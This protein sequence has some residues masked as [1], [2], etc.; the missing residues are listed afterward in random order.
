M[1]PYS[2]GRN[3]G[4]HIA[5]RPNAVKHH[6]GIMKETDINKL[7]EVY[8]S[9]CQFT[10]NLRPATLRGYRAA[11][12]VFVMVVE[13]VTLEGLNEDTMNYFFKG[14]R[15]RKRIVG[16]NKVKTD[17]RD[18]T[19]KTYWSKLNSFFEWLRIRGHINSNPLSNVRVA[20]PVYDDKR[21]LGLDEIDRIYAAITKHSGSALIRKRD[22]LIVSLLRYTGIRKG[23]LLGLQFKDADMDRKMLTIR[24]ET[25]KSKRTRSIPMHAT[26]WAH[27]DDY[28]QEVRK[29]NYKT[30]RLIV[31][32][33]GDWGFTAHG[34]KH[35]VEQM[36]KLSGVKFHLHRFRH[37]FA[38]EFARV[39]LD[40][41]ILMKF[42]GHVDP[43]MTERYTRSLD[44]EDLRKYV[45]L[46][47]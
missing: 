26:L 23:E 19:V 8:M 25:S 12:D 10:Q 18:S 37:T 17:V 11:F 36:A 41:P 42:M 24:G 28:L 14:L 1:V 38:T 46:M 43:R 40:T 34:M 5:S 22:T 16:N 31:S 32:K 35:W 7:F 47:K 45:H 21:A 44:G 27:M 30:E 4:L 13:N 2:S 20:E 39:G 3:S 29:R 15:T 6:G 9:E 33:N